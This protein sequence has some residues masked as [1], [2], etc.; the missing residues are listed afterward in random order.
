[1]TQPTGSDHRIDDEVSL[2]ELARILFL[3]RWLLLAGVGIGLGISGY[4]AVF[5]QEVYSATVVVTAAAKSGSSNRLSG[6]ASQLGLNDGGAD[7]SLGVSASPALLEVLAKSDALLGRLVDDSVSVGPFGSRD[8]L[9]AMF[10]PKGETP[11]E[12]RRLLAVRALKSAITTRNNKMTGTL[13]I[14]VSTPSPEVSHAIALA[15]VNRLN[16]Y[17]LLLG[18]QQASE[19]RRVAISSLVERKSQL[20]AAED[21]MATFLTKNRQYQSS[22]HLM[23]EYER[24]QREVSLN[25]EVLVR[26]SQAIEEAGLR[27]ARDAPVVMVLEPAEVPLLPKPRKRLQALAIGLF[28]GFLVGALAAFARFALV[29]QGWSVGRNGLVASASA[30][31]S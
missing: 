21:R 23:F 18:R 8:T 14:E 31:K 26:L 30:R 3:E 27:E 17:L 9:L 13:A 5:R 1:M 16:D 19:E 11:P 15:L 28:G 4:F 6:L 22:P 2:L 29:Q 24:I 12:L 7:G 20:R 10:G 25:Q